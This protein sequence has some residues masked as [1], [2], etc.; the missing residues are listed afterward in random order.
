MA[1]YRDDI[2]ILTSKDLGEADTLYVVYGKRRGRFS[3]VAN[4]VRRL[5]SRKRGHLQTFNL[6]KVSCAEGRNL[7]IIIEADSYFSVDTDII[8]SEEYDRIGL[9]GMALL[10]F[11]PEGVPE[12]KLFELWECYIQGL[13]TEDRTK[14]FVCEVLLIEGFL[15]DEQ[16]EFFGSGS[17]PGLNHLRAYIQ[18]ILDTA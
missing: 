18:K 10:K 3:A 14:R 6:C 13:L 11:T 12:R 15:T 4:G 17:K 5:N 1:I 16:Y 7:D 8:S 2:A 9:A